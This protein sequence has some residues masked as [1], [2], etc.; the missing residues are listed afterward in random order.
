MSE[1]KTLEWK[2][3]ELI[4]IDCTKLPT[5]EEYVIC[6]DYK[7]L[8]EAIKILVVR[9]A[10]AIGVSAAYGVVLAAIQAQKETGTQKEYIDFIKKAIEEL[11]ETR[12]TAVNLF[13]D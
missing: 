12:P 2:N 8:A 3:D 6:K 13:W 7:T 9:G 10:P 11:A 1:V 5:S 4:L